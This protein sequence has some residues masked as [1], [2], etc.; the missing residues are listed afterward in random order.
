MAPEHA[1]SRCHH[2]L[3]LRVYVPRTPQEG[4]RTLCWL[5]L[6]RR[7]A[8]PQHGVKRLRSLCQ[9][10]ADRLHS[11]KPRREGFRL[12]SQWYASREEARMS[13]S[14]KFAEFGPFRLF[15]SERRLVMEGQ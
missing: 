12:D 5:T 13:S 14:V 11:S 8:S 2:K 4:N 15:P 7:T 10:P 1:K 3:L 6:N 9:S